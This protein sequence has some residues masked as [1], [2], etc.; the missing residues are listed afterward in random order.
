MMCYMYT[1]YGTL[2]EH[3]MMSSLDIILFLLQIVS[4]LVNNTLETCELDVSEK[5]PESKSLAKLRLPGHRSDVRTTCFSSD[6][7]AILSA[8]AE[9]MKIWNR[10]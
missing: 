7:T 8:S 5:R 3:F 2:N 4:L 1:R 9:V 6:N 10:Y